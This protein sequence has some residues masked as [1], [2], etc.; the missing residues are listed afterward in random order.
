MRTERARLVHHAG[1]PVRR[2]DAFRCDAAFDPLFERCQKV[3][4]V[5]ARLAEDRD[6][7]RTLQQTN[8]RKFL[9][10]FGRGLAVTGFE[11]SDA[12]G[13]YLLEPYE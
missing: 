2:D 11:R 4:L 13:S 3:E 12:E 5:G 6:G 9:E 10:A 7:A 1:S 8:A